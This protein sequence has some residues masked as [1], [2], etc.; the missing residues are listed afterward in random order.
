MNNTISLRITFACL[1]AFGL[2]AITYPQTANKN[3]ITTY[4]P[5]VPLTDE[6][7]V[8]TQSKENC[9]KTVQYFD[10]LGRADQTIQVA[11]SPLGK[12][13]VQPIE[14][15][16]YGREAKKYLPYKGGNSNGNY[17]TSD[18]SEQSSYYLS[19]FPSSPDK[20]YPFAV[21][22]YENSPLNRVLMQ[23]APGYAWQPVQPANQRPVRYH[24]ATNITK[25]ARLWTVNPNNSITT[26]GYY[27]PGKLYKTVIK[28]ENWTT[29][30]GNLNTTEEYKDLQ[31]NVVLKRSY[32]NVGSN[33]DSVETYYI[34][35]DFGLLRYVLPPLAVKNR[36]TQPTLYPS[37][38]LVKNLCY[39]Y[40]YDA[41][42]RMIIKQIPGVGQVHLVYDNRD[43]LIASQDSVQRSSSKW[44]VTKYDNLNRPVMTA[45]KYYP[46]TESRLSLQTYL[47]NYKSPSIFY[48]SRTTTGVGFTLINSFN[49]K[50]SLAEADLLSVSYYD[51]YAYPDTI[52]FNNNV[53]VSNYYNSTTGKYYCE[54]TKSLVTGTRAK[55]LDGNEH[56]SSGKWLVSTIYYD[57]KYRPIQTLRDLY[58]T[59]ATANYNEIVSTL[60]DFVGKTMKT[61]TRQ[62]FNGNPNTVTDTCIYD[63]AERLTQIQQQLNSGPKVILAS[64]GYNELGQLITKKLHKVSEGVYAQ[65]LNYTYNIRGWLTGINDPDNPGSD[66]FAIKLLYENNSGISNI[67]S[68][69]QYNGNISGI[70]WKNGEIAVKGYGFTYD[71]LNRMIGADFGEATGFLSKADR[72]NEAVTYDYN[73]N[74]VSLTRS[75]YNGDAYYSNLDLLNYTYYDSGN[76]LRNITDNGQ[77]SYGFID[78]TNASDYSYDPNGNL[79]Q[80]LN[81]GIIEIKYNDLHLPSEIKKDAAHKVIYNFDATGNKIK[82]QVINGT[83]P[84]DK[85][86]CGIF[87]YNTN[88]LL[89]LIHTG[90]GIA[91]KTSSTFDYEYH[92]KD[93]LGSVR[94]AFKISNGVASPTQYT[95]FY[96][97]GMISKFW[98]SSDNKYLFNGKELQDE[99]LGGVNLD[100]YDFGF[101]YFDPQIGRFTTM[102]PLA[103]ERLWI[104]PYNY[105]QNNPLNRVDPTGGLD[106]WIEDLKT[107]ELTWDEKINSQEDFDKSGYNKSKFSYAGQELQRAWSLGSTA[108]IYTQYYGP[109]GNTSI[110]DYPMWVET[111]KSHIGLTEGGNPVI[112]GMIDNMNN[113]FPRTDGKKPIYDDSEPWCGVFVYSCL[114]ETGQQVSSNSW[115]TPALNTFYSNNWNE[116]TAI[117]N[118]K[119]GSIAV[120]SYGHVGMIVG[121]DNKNIWLLGGNQQKNGAVVRDGVE[122]NITRYPRS[123]VSKYVIPT[124]YNPPPLGTFK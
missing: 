68:S 3:Y 66:L 20:D 94:H 69:P 73:G 22:V 103:E 105:V 92:L 16:Q 1:I 80:D 37:T 48:E 121:F 89:D 27:L 122:V 55:V 59:D 97:F 11:L 99:S 60:Y 5:K 115:Q 40:Q 41:K 98:G 63:H 70:K 67:V 79:T 106:G 57:D 118:P 49:L 101:R 72:Y 84:I 42:K 9:I 82:K 71:A 88:K 28:D 77:K 91:Y 46:N 13:I 76:K 65:E 90:E 111:G 96:P 45:L 120:M 25:D 26:S 43:R 86:Y 24:Y 100:W 56:N 47:D 102:D 10:G 107:E 119:Y 19:Q 78:V 23:G 51:T 36:G 117:S 110:Y 87:E 85:Y 61:Q 15:D 30:S 109:D 123:L 4:V 83:T 35:D 116:G 81:K 104:S 114:S 2:L 32:I 93:H 14:Y 112:Q 53:R 12:D 6:M 64:M 75:G 33:I 7:S 113:S 95:E 62:V 39:Y 50:F 31:G 29:S 52:D 58:S 21:T 8:P 124:G 44:L 38:P 54:L 18:I 74:I 108:G 34:Y 17:I